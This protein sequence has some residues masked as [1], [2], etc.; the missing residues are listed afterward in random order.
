V[1]FFTALKMK[2]GCNVCLQPFS[3]LNNGP[4][5]QVLP[6]PQTFFGHH[7]QHQKVAA[8]FL[9]ICFC[10]I[11]VSI[12]KNIIMNLIIPDNLFLSMII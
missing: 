12:H 3:T 8:A 4:V 11:F 7:G 5:F 2:K 9:A 1:G 6:L 10:L